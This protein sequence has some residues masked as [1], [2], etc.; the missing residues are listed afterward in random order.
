MTERNIT[1][2][3]IEKCVTNLKV[4]PA[5]LLEGRDYLC[6]S[7]SGPLHEAT[8]TAQTQILKRILK[9]DQNTV[10]ISLVNIDPLTEEGLE[11]E[12][13]DLIR[14]VTTLKAK[15]KTPVF[16]KCPPLLKEHLGKKIPFQL[17]FSDNLAA[18]QGRSRGQG[19]FS[20]E[21]DSIIEATQTVF[22]KQF[23]T[24]ADLLPPAKATPCS[25]GL[26]I[27]SEVIGTIELSSTQL[28]GQL[29]FAMP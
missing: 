22:Q 24:K 19:D 15:K 28:N 9:L 29:V 12:A 2:D 7:L 20:K 5:E 26:K 4:A 11:T 25:P 16:I 17:E 18:V 1:L 8:K 3:L 13:S 14:L 6:V 21:F 10:A 23:N 27:Q